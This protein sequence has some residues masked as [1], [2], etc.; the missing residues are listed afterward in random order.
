M[1]KILIIITGML[2]LGKYA[3]GQYYL[4]VEITGLK[5]NSGVILFQ[6][7]DEKEKIVTQLKG[8][9]KELKSSIIINDLKPGKYGFRY[10]HDEDMS[11]RLET[12][13]FGIPKEGY[14]F[15]NDA[16]GPFGPKP[17]KEWLFELNQ[18][19]NLSVKTRY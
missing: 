4:Q 5:N 17:F 7:F 18:N 10:F 2:I 1:K 15:S 19:K 6:L 9:I 13:A 16:A 3:C 8:D 11:G 14:G 12:N